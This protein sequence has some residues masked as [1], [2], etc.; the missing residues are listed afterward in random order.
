[1]APIVLGVVIA[2][3]LSFTLLISNQFKIGALVIATESMTGELN[4]GDFVIF[5]KIDQN[6]ELEKGNII[7]F[8]KNKN[9]IVH[10]IVEIEN[11]D[12][13]ERYYTKG[14]ANENMDEGYIV[15]SEIV[16]ITHFKISYLGYPTLWLRDLF[17]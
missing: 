17:D 3:A 9:Y 2:L 14:D 7:V 16:G 4:K 5:E 11:I 15:R 12:N 13:E 10:R 1:V 6:D 8:E